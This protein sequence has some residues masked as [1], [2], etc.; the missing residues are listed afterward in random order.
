MKC[1]AESEEEHNRENRAGGAQF[2]GE[3]GSV[4]PHSFWHYWKPTTQTSSDFSIASLPSHCGWRLFWS[5]VFPV[6]HK[7]RFRLLRGFFVDTSVAHIVAG[8]CACV[9]SV[10]LPCGPVP[11]FWIRLI[12]TNPQKCWDFFT[13]SVPAHCCGRCCGRSCG[14]RGPNVYLH[15]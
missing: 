8:V 10:V 5:D 1:R 4:P 3:K 2:V 9:W 6:T 12:E 13:C 7:P 15:F 14:L 11:V